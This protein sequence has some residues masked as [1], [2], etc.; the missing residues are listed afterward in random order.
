MDLI[1]KPIQMCQVFKPVVSFEFFKRWMHF[2]SFCSELDQSNVTEDTPEGEEHPPADS[3]NKCVHSQL[4][5]RATLLSHCST[6]AFCLIK[7][8]CHLLL[9]IALG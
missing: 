9:K 3:E 2:F 4:L 1:H 5:I 6:F 8:C 7:I